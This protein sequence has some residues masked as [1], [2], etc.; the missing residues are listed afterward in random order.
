MK[1]IYQTEDKNCMQTTIASLLDLE[2][3]DVPDFSKMKN[4]NHE[5]MKFLIERGYSIDTI[6]NTNVNKY[7]GDEKEYTN[8][9]ND[10]KNLNGVGGYFYG[11]VMSPK[12]YKPDLPIYNE[13]QIHHA[14]IIDK[15]FNIVNPINK[16]YENTK[17]P[18]CDEIGYNG[19]LYILVIN[20]NV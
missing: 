4:P 15:N 12:Y 17:F 20:K 16:E 13:N 14:V 9:L 1:L 11:V 7:E 6:Y 8:Y 19:L 2:L 18:L 3:S 10:I 5:E